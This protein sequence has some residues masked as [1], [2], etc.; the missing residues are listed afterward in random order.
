MLIE[1][2]ALDRIKL[3]KWNDDDKSSLAY[4]ANNKKIFDNLRDAFPFPYSLENAVEFIRAAQCCG[5]DS[6]FFAIDLK[7]KA[8]G[9]IGAFLKKDVYRKNAE[10]GYW[11]GEEYWGNGIMSFV[12]EKIAKLI[13][14]KYDITRIYAEPY[15]RNIG[16]RQ[17]LE[18][19]GFHCEAVLEKNVYKNGELI[20]SCIYSLLKEEGV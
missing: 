15:S 13:F 17:A 20:D 8:I 4:L 6:L 9:S 14:E 1:T 11:L 16:S 3:R 2:I 18:K 19:A 12:I 5:P 7:G 10:I